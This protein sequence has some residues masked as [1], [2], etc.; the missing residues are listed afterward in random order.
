MVSTISLILLAAGA[1]CLYTAYNVDKTSRK[2]TK[3]EDNPYSMDYS[4]D[5][6]NKYSGTLPLHSTNLEYGDSG[7]TAERDFY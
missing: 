5:F 6:S 1:Y 3:Q 2:S 4:S 7:R